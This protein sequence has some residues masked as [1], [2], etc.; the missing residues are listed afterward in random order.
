[1]Q[2]LI[3]TF[4]TAGPVFDTSTPLSFFTNVAS[5][6][7]SSE[8]NVNL[9]RLEVYPTNQYTPAVHRLLQ[10]TANIVDAQ[11]TNFYPSIF[12]PLFSKD[13]SN[14]IFIIGYEPVTNVSGPSDPQL[15]S[16]YEV[17]RLPNFSGATNPLTDRFGPVNFYGVPW[18]IGAKNGL[19]NFNQLSLLTAATV[20][21]KLEVSRTTLDPK[22]ATY[23]TN[24]AYIFWVTN[25][26]GVTF[27]NSYSNALSSTQYNGQPI[28][29]VVLD[30]VQMSMTNQWYGFQNWGART[31]FYTNIALN[32][33]PGAGWGA[34]GASPP[35]QPPQSKSF[36]PFSWPMVY[37][38]PLVYNSA[39]H[40]F[41]GGTF[42]PLSQLDQLGL[43]VTNYLQAYILIG[44]QVVDYV[45]LRSPV[46]VGGINQTLAD[47]NFGVSGNTYY[48]WSTNDYNE[49]PDIPYGVAN[50]LHVSGNPA[51]APS[52]GGSWSQLQT[53]MGAETPSAEA[54]YFDGFFTRSFAWAGKIYQ[55][56]EL[57]IQA[58][59]TPHRTIYSSYLLQANDPLVHYMDSDLGA[60][61]GIPAIWANGTF[62]N[63][64]WGRSDD[65]ATE[66]LPVPPLSPIGGRYQPW[67]RS[68]QMARIAGVDGNPYNVAY[69]DPLLWSPDHWNFPTG[70]AWNLNWVGQ[71]HRGT[72][73]QSIFLKSTNLLAISLDSTNAIDGLLTWEAWTGDYLQT[74]NTGLFSDAVGSA[75]IM[76]WQLV[77]FLAAALDTNDYGQQFSVNDTNTN[78]WAALLNGM[79]ALTNT[80]ILPFPT[81]QLQ[82]S[83]LVISSNSPQARIIANAIQTTRLNTNLFPNPTF[84]E[85]GLVLATPELSVA[86]PFLNTNTVSRG[87]GTGGPLYYGITDQAYEMIPSQLLPLLRI[88]AVV[89]ML[90][91]N[92]QAELEFGGY[93]G[94]EYAVQTS[95]DLVNWSD[96][97]TNQTAL[98]TSTITLPPTTNHLQFYR[99]RLL[100]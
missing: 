56:L 65:T 72:P 68:G 9:S 32:T 96:L 67:G 82:F 83:T 94:L 62:Q 7:L 10:V 54:A 8:L 70:Q 71:V 88:D 66:P 64:V 44:N 43:V 20:V 85:I 22:T 38:S 59:Y 1:V 63:G 34:N 48:Q 55:N 23:T 15:A 30:E 50:Q 77:S 27:W 47:P 17:A 53:P 97:S 19:P 93:D 12:R 84:G 76:D 40:N 80:A 11:N 92:G 5:R 16:P 33:W 35:N 73:W 90:S 18:V 42:E 26:L 89:K 100:Q 95:P 57:A 81:T 61:S 74:T 29:V 91:P 3:A 69:K 25:Q 87:S 98:G 60:Q 78:A 75:P 52:A 37:L 13:A 51:S 36:V 46:I 21:R 4:A 41:N 86:S 49:N 39:T 24:Q 31:H 79:V 14:N 99:T 45:Q 28:Q 6:L 58:P 2:I